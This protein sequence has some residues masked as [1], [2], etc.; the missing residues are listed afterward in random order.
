[1]N[2]DIEVYLSYFAP[3]KTDILLQIEGTEQGSQSIVSANIDIPFTDHFV[4]IEADDG[5][6]ERIWLRTTGEFRCT[7]NARIKVK[8]EA[9]EIA[10]LKSTPVHKLPAAAIRYLMPSRYCPSGEFQQFVH[11]KFDGKKGGKK[12]V[13]IRDWI[14]KNIQYVPGASNFLTTAGDTFVHRQGV[15]RDFAHVMI[16][17]ARAGGIPARYASVYSPDVMPQDFH[18]I[19]EVWLDGAWHMVDATGMS[20]PQSTIRIG[21]GQDSADVAFLTGFGNIDFNAQNVW[22]KRV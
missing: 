11:D 3:Q 18:A 6:G 9:V 22:V 20:N 19:A 5:Y 4:R 12:I 21:V 16:S 2:V 15:C 8:R 17:L 13:A 14:L 7:Y 10:D 1:M